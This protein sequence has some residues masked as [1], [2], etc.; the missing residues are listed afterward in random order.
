MPAARRSRPCE[1]TWLT[2]ECP[3][4]R[5]IAIGLKVRTAQPTMGIQSTSRLS[6]HEAGGTTNICAIVSQAE[7]C[8]HSEMKGRDGRCSRPSIVYRS[9]QTDPASPYGTVAG[10]TGGGPGFATAAYRFP[11]VGGHTV[12]I[13]ALVN[14]DGGDTATGIAFTLA[15]HLA[16]RL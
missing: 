13:V 3:A 4:L 5:L 15:A 6:N 11:D 10:H 7:E 9:P 16:A 12:T 2:A 1:T 14:R 8:F